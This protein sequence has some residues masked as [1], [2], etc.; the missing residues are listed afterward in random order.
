M[1]HAIHPVLEPVPVAP[2]PCAGH[3]PLH[4][5]ATGEHDCLLLVIATLGIEIPFAIFLLVSILYLTCAASL[6]HCLVSC[7]VLV[8]SRLP[9][10]ATDNNGGVPTLVY[11]GTCGLPLND[12]L[13]DLLLGRFEY[14]YALS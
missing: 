3:D 12:C 6:S 14:S 7:N 2:S 8:D 10:V 11:S 4:F 9:S 13:I 5:D 1:G